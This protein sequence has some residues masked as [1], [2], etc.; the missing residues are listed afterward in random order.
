M[1]DISI[2]FQLRNSKK[3]LESLQKYIFSTTE[4]TEKYID[5][6]VNQLMMLFTLPHQEAVGRVNRHWSNINRMDDDGMIF[7]MLPDEWAHE[8]YY[9][10]NSFWWKK[11]KKDLI[12]LPFN[13]V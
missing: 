5:E 1:T 2:A 12:P 11:D 6:I 9:G 3:G 10:S 7:H 8:V 4:K 13:E